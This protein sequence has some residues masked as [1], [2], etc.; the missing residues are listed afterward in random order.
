MP[1]KKKLRKFTS[2]KTRTEVIKEFD[3]EFTI[4]NF[5][6]KKNFNLDKRDHEKLERSFNTPGIFNSEYAICEAI[7]YPILSEVAYYNNLPLWSHAPLESVEANLSGTP[8]YLLALSEKGGELYKKAIVCVG[9]A[10]KDDFQGGWAQVTA[11]MVAA[12]KENNKDDIP[13]YGLVTTGKSWEF[14][15]LKNNNFTLHK[16]AISATQ[17]FQDVLDCL[18]WIFFE[19][20]KNADILEEL[21]NK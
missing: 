16:E 14:A 13:V 19:A 5:V 18:N 9:E 2:F 21:D 20:K 6:K 4:E 1:R 17:N 8:D 7:L 10:K 11:E 15:V 3:L 12:Q